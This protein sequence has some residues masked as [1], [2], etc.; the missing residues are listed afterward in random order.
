M[1]APTLVMNR[2]QVQYPDYDVAMRL[3]SSIPDARLVALEG[4][5]LCMYLG[6]TRAAGHSI[7]EFLA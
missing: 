3:A 2:R 1:T 6:D 7:D 4:D 5:S